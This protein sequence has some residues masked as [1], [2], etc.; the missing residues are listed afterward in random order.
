[1]ICSKCK[2]SGELK[3]FQ[4]FQYFYC[5]QCKEEIELE[6]AP[7]FYAD[8]EL[9]TDFSAD[10]LLEEFERMINEPDEASNNS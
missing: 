3:T 1:M 4:T 9:K 7:K 5:K 8:E 10:E 2:K 6:E